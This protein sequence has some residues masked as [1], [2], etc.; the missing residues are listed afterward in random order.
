MFIDMHEALFQYIE[1]KSEQK[2]TEGELQLIKSKFHPKR[3]RKKQYFLQEGDVCKYIAFIVHGSA[4]MFS[5][6]DKGDEHIVRFALESWWLGDTESFNLLTPSRYN[7]EILEDSEMLIISVA[8]A[9]DLRDQNQPF[10]LT[11]RAMDKQ[12]SIATQKRIHAAISMTA[13]ERYEDLA[14][15]Y[16]QFL[17]RFSQ[18]MIASYLGL[19]PETLSR[20]RKN[21][22][23]K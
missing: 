9:V 1:L 4:R 16:P 3:M 14:N 13:E 11:I 15:T 6:D 12:L 23:R 18:S 2:L 17:Q 7:I 5:V 8:D 20:I 22:I 21:S 19:S 10:N